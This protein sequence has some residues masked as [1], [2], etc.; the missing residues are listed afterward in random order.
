MICWNICWTS[1]ICHYPVIYCCLCTH[2]QPCVSAC[3]HVCVYMLA[4]MFHSFHICPFACPLVFQSVSVSV[5][6]SIFLPVHVKQSRCLLSGIWRLLYHRLGGQTTEPEAVF[7]NGREFRLYVG[8]KEETLFLG[9]TETAREYA[10]Y[11][12]FIYAR[13]RQY[14]VYRR[15]VSPDRCSHTNT[16]TTCDDLHLFMQTDTRVRTYAHISMHM[17]IQ[18]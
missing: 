12:I 11:G 2:V 16:H 1:I 13:W 3:L 5:S 14:S 17:R 4:Y 10:K 7:R 9:R 8:P 6:P 18:A 15:R